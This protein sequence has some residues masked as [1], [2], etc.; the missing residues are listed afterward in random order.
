MTDT[1]FSCNICNKKYASNSSLWNHNKKFHKV[2]GMHIVTQSVVHCVPNVVHN[3]EG[4][5]VYT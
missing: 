1:I 3:N 5:S 4:K 2:Q